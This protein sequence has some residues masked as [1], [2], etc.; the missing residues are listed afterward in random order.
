MRKL[1]SVL[2]AALLVGCGQAVPSP[3]PTPESRARS[4]VP[5]VRGA[6]DLPTINGHIIG[7]AFV[8]PEFCAAMED[9]VGR[10]APGAIRS[11]SWHHERF[12]DAAGNEF[13]ATTGGL[14]QQVAVAVVHLAD[15]RVTALAVDCGPDPA[16]YD[17]QLAMACKAR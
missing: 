8:C 16:T 13:I 6:T 2:V 9:A 5:D 14:W 3:T 1:A 11:I 15:G 4:G 12:F 7:D 10:A 17:T